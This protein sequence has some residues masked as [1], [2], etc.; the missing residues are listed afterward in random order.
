MEFKMIKKDETIIKRDENN[1]QVSL[2]I[3]VV[4]EHYKLYNYFLISKKY[5]DNILFNY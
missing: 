2:S 4:K 3:Q 1:R 5:N